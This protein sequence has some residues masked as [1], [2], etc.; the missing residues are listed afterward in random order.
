MAVKVIDVSS[1][2]PNINYA[3]VKK[4]GISGAII[5]SSLTYWGDQSMVKESYVDK[6]YQGFHDVGIP[7]GVYHYSCATTSELARKEARLVLDIVKDKQI[8]YPIYFDTENNER[9]GVLSKSALTEVAIAF[10]DEIEKAGYY[11]GIY[12]SL[13]WLENKLDLSKLEAY[14]KWVAQ[15]YT[16]CQFTGSYGMWQYTSQGKVDGIS[17]NVDMNECY[18]NYP[19][20][21][22]NAGLNH[23]TATN[24]SVKPSVPSKPVEPVAKFQKGDKVK[25]T[26]AIQYDTGASFTTYYDSYDVIEVAG[27][28]VVIGIGSTV[29]AAVHAN[30]LAK[31]GSTAQ[32]VAIKVG[33]QVRVKSGAKDYTGGSLASFVYQTTYT[34]QELSGKRAVIGVNGAVTAAVNTDNL[35][36]V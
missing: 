8:E 31:V 11:A 34:V 19:S 32:A 9:Q 36:K 20:T 13:N 2:Q 6:H 24:T 29:T 14:D 35:Y 7:V 33:D 30:N 21:I 18:V 25:V 23:L 10:C 4:A 22:R 12:A 1:F 5:R 3:A 26:K 28:R 16:E 17:G 15:Y 27:D